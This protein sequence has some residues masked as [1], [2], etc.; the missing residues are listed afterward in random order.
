MA[1]ILRRFSKIKYLKNKRR[2]NKKKRSGAKR[3]FKIYKEKDFKKYKKMSNETTGRVIYTYILKDI[4]NDIY[5]IGKTTAPLR[6]F[7]SLCIKD[8]VVPIALVAKDVEKE[9]H[10]LYK[11][12]RIINEEYVRNGMTEWFKKGGKFT[13]FI[14]GIDNGRVLPY[15]TIYSLFEY[16]LENTTVLM[17]D[18]STAWEI[19]QEDLGYFFIM[20]RIMKA[21][22][23]IKYSGG[24]FV[25][26]KKFSDDILII[27]KR[28]SVN[29]NILDYI[30][31]NYD[32]FISTEKNDIIKHDRYKEEGYIATSVFLDK[33]VKDRKAY[34][35][36]NKKKTNG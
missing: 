12:N 9:L 21:L 24:H 35:L 11:D 16:L 18:Q 17:A 8:K 33:E 27:Q 31:N 26:T 7:K 14:K 34:I 4:E 23:M 28:I 15:I 22:K 36:I 1:I 6:R 19:S 32:I 29:N 20:R 3:K 5:K 13:E 10:E 30:T 25:P 2:V